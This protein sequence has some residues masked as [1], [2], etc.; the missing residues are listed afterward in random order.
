MT[1]ASDN[2]FPSILIT[3][4]TEPSAPAAGKQRLYIDSTT[5]LLKATNSSG[6]DRTIEGLSNP[7]TTAGD[8]IYGGASGVPTR[9]PVG[10]ANQ[11][12]RTNAGATAPEW[13]AASGGVGA[14]AIVRYVTGDITLGS[15]TSMVVL[16][17]PGDCVVTAA[18]GDLLMVG[19]SART[20]DTDGDSL[21]MDFATIVSAAVVNYGSSLTNTALV[22]GIPGWWFGISRTEGAGATYPYVV[23]SGDISGGTVTLRLYYRV[24]GTGKVLG[25]S[26]TIPLIFW[27]KNLLQ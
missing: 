8:I 7:M 16:S 15:G 23:Q 10:T 21:A 22:T 27:V 20:T 1:K 17:G 18:A 2:A 4:A 14:Y 12:L 13:A 3:E 6:T 26:S 5:H 11:V 19:L 24:S 9:L 25:A